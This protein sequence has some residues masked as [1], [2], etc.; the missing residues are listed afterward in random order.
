M[1]CDVLNLEW[2]SS[3]RDR[4]VATAICHTL[5]RRGYRVLEES[6]FNY[7]YFLLKHRPRLLYLAEPAGARLNYEAMLFADAL[8]IPT[9]SVDAEGNYVEEMVDQTFWGHVTDRRLRQ[10]L[11]LLWSARSRDMVL[12]TAPQLRDRLRVTGAVGFDRYRLRSFASKDDWRRKYGFAQE[13]VVGYASWAF[14]YVFGTDSVSQDVSS[15]GPATVDRF[16][17]DCDALREILAAL[18]RRRPNTLFLVKQHPGVVD[19]THSELAGLDRHDNVL[20]IRN[21]EPIADCINVCDV[22]MAYDSTTCIEAWLLEKPTLLINPSGGDFP[23]TRIHMGSPILESADAVNDALAHHETTGEV[24][25]FNAKATGRHRVVTDTLQ[26]ADGKNHL[27]AA[28][29]ME[30]LLRETPADPACFSL[31]LRFA[32]YKQNLLYR[33]ARY[34]PR[35]PGFRNYTTGRRAFDRAELALAERRAAGAMKS[36]PGALSQQELAELERVNS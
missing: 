9:V 16:R 6:I 11:K 4:E 14:N 19:D 32:A 28:H 2:S 27:R 10:R 1:T 22:W 20:R 21:E 17:R 30:G 33:G 18:I 3:G 15:L 26:W 8:R 13:R 23:R 29:Y 25:G 12:S 35:L 36:F 5:R 31:A 24:P 7:K 34:L